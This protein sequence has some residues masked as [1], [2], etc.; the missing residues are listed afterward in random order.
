MKWR[1]SSK[2]SERENIN[3][4]KEIKKN[5]DKHLNFALLNGNQELGELSGLVPR[6]REVI[7]E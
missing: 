5:N 1:S 6:S 4:W 2:I 7:M 3:V